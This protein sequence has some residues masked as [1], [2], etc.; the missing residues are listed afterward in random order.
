MLGY[1]IYEVLP[2]VGYA[3]PAGENRW[4]RTEP[5][6]EQEFCLADKVVE[7][8]KASGQ[9]PPYVTMVSCPCSRC[10]MVQ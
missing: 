9:K 3:R 2:G 5:T 8:M 4:V 7:S 1:E 10:R 6:F